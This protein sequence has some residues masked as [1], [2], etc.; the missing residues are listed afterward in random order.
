MGRMNTTA[1]T[2][3]AT[4]DDRTARTRPGALDALS[5][6]PLLPVIAMVAG[7]FSFW[8]PGFGTSFN[9][10]AIALM[11]APLLVAASGATLIMLVGG[12]DLS[13]GAVMSLAS[14]LG[15]TV[16]RDSGNVPLGVA[17]GVGV[18]LAVGC[19]NG[20]AV[21]R[22]R[23]APFVY[24]LGM[25]LTVR[26]IAFLFSRG[27][28]VG[29]LPREA[30]AFGRSAILGIPT[31]MW[32]AMSIFAFCLML[33]YRTPFG[34]MVYLVG[35]NERAAIFNALPVQSVKFWVYATGGLFG[36]IAGMLAVLRLGSGAPVLGDTILLQ[37]IAAVVVGGTSVF[38]G[39]GGLWRTATGAIL[40]VM[41][42]KGLDLLGVA[43]YDQAIAIG[44]VILL[45][46][47]A[48]SWLRRRTRS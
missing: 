48:G 25:L 12:I 40:M 4:P 18:G 37:V 10:N 5:Q 24:T 1:T 30:T 36:G 39:Q 43:F 19:M 2:T 45:G 8:V 32:I 14:V 42:Q 46:S 15:A 28:S 22:V 3:I 23:L 6:L 11:L 16:M 31:L 29:Q 26:A 33:L 20:F 41:L 9:V 35:A 47:A 34:R 17:A 44:V 38:G 13:V 21:A 27:Y 7:C